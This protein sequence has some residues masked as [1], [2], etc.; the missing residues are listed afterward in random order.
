MRQHPEPAQAHPDQVAAIVTP[1]NSAAVAALNAYQRSGRFH[2]YT[3]PEHTTRILV[4][5]NDGWRC[6]DCHYR[7]NWAL[8]ESADI[9]QNIIAE[10]WQ[11]AFNTTAGTR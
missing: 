5:H 6:P 9:G 8:A 3:C 1:W 4:A 10:Q 2:G 7:Q 11:A